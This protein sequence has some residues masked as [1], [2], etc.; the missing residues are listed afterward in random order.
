MSKF[1]GNISCL[2][3]SLH[4]SKIKVSL[5][6]QWWQ[7]SSSVLCKKHLD[8]K[9][10]WII[11]N[12]T[13]SCYCLGTQPYEYIMPNLNLIK[14]FK[15]TATLQEKQELEE[16]VK[17]IVQR[18]NQPNPDFGKFHRTSFLSIDSFW[19]YSLGPLAPSQQWMSP[20]YLLCWSTYFF[21][22]ILFL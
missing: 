20:K 12:F 2:W 22:F 14:S 21:N 3:C 18:C 15:L 9:K 6:T 4:D 7:I 13:L 11:T 17:K 1:Q 8:S 5:A 19:R 16:Q 10:Y